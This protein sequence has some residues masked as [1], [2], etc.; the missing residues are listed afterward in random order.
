MAHRLPKTSARAGFTLIEVM[1]SLSLFALLGA[2]LYGAMSIGQA[3]SQKGQASFE[4][5]QHLRSVMDLLGSYMRSAYPFRAS[6]Q[7][8]AI[9]YQGDEEELSFVS[10]YSIAMGGR[11]MA[12]IHVRWDRDSGGTG[13]LKL[14]E[15]LP[16]SADG[17]TS[18]G[19]R[20]SFVLREG[21]S[22]FHF[23]YLDP[24]PEKDDWA[25]KWDGKEKRMLP[26]A[27]R[28][29]FRGAGGPEIQWV[30]PVMMTVLA[31]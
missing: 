9:F 12:K 2:I 20:N 26:R 28:L 19:Y 17:E 31:P 5:N 1:L 10:A 30:F 23:S 27:V 24:Q 4:K 13:A 16:A 18:G 14:D 6:L 25:E 3:A 7:D 21:I 29:T 8:P 15:E 11:G 22:E